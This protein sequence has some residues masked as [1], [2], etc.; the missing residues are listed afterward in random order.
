M[1]Y[2]KKRS[3][4]KDMAAVMAVT[5]VMLAAGCG[6]A[7]SERER[8]VEICS[9]FYKN[10]GEDLKRENGTEEVRRLVNVLGESGCPAVD[11]RNQ[12]DMTRAQEVISF[13][14]KKE[15]GE[16]EEL[17]VVEVGYGNDF[18]IYEL[19]TEGGAVD[20]RRSYYK[21]VNGKAEKKSEGVYRAEVWKYTEE[22]YL[23]FSGTWDSLEQSVLTMSE[24]Q[25]HT[26]LRVRP[27]E[28]RYREWNR[29]YL[30]PVGYEQNNLFLTD[31][32]GEDFG[33]IDFYDAF[34]IFYPLVYGEE[35]PYKADEN[36]GKGAVYRIPKEEFES[37]VMEFFDIDSETLQEKTIYHAEDQT[38][39]YRPR[40]IY[41]VEYPEYP[42][43]EVTGAC[44]NGDG[45]ITLTVQA[46]FPYEDDSRALAHEVT[47]RSEK[48]GRVKYLSNKRIF[49]EDSGDE[50]WHTPRL[51]EEEW[52]SVYEGNDMEQ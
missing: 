43:P 41:E 35:V 21:F 38:Y 30:L 37:V 40:G 9:D 42:Y 33:E 22:G 20:V 44:Q 4:G 3:F 15:A 36:L 1:R 7:V 52:K 47:I 50:S 14:E 26:A 6:E 11:N 2:G 13:C 45:T 17:A 16:K 49:P 29:A 31:W 18:V 5:A 34:D 24:T 46:V 28:E 8:L 51:T 39:E 27:L 48:D 23:L 10:E 12:T 19:D 25:E 32:S